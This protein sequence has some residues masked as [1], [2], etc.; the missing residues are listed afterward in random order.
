MDDVKISERSMVMKELLSMKELP[1]AEERECAEYHNPA[2]G[3]QAW[4]KRS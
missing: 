3:R 4:I 2:I 1:I